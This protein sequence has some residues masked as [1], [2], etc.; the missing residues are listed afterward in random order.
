M[1]V[2]D[3]GVFNGMKHDDVLSSSLEA[4]LGSGN[5][6]I[7]LSS[8]ALVSHVPDLHDPYLYICIVNMD[9]LH[10]ELVLVASSLNFQDFEVRKGLGK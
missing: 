5:M 1:S 10:Y 2:V 7:F 3:F 4:M 9:N 8:Y 6:L